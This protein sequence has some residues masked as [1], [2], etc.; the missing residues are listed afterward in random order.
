MA[1][2]ETLY[3]AKPNIKVIISWLFNKFL[4]HFLMV[5]ALFFWAVYPLVYY[6]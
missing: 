1:M 6:T 3:E 5:G 4:L 2:E